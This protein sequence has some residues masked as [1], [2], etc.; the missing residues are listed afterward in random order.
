M[1]SW[2]DD[3]R[4]HAR[5]ILQAALEAVSPQV[6]MRQVARDADALVLPEGTRV[7]LAGRTVRVVALGKAAGMMAAHA[8]PWGPLAEVVVSAPYRVDIPGFEAYV[9]AHPLPDEES[10]RAG[11]RA[12]E[13]ARATGPD[14][15]LILLLSGGASAMAEAPAVPLDD[16]RRANEALLANGA[17]IEELNLVRRHLSRLKG[18]GLARACRGELLALCISDVDDVATLGSG[19]AWPDASRRADALRA[20]ERR[21][22][23][24]V[25]PRSVREHL[26][27]DE[28]PAPRLAPPRHVV[29]ADNETALRAAAARAAALGYEARVRERWLRGEA[30]ER[31]RELGALAREPVARPTAHLAGGETTVRVVG[32][33]RGGRNQ[34]VALAAVDALSARDALLATMGTDGVDGPTDAAGA[35][36]D[37]LTRARADALGLDAHAHLAENDAYAYF[38]ALDDLIRTGPTGTNVRDVALLLV[39]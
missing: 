37:G 15:L 9:G 2:R 16:L 28:P 26:A 36:V 34:E 21:G 14:D 30:R 6:A 25:V 18:G 10:V 24:D 22:L 1:R 11:E 17:P 39:R 3:A 12:L 7:R 31:G 27:R 29:L 13:L 32:G 35:I 19:P 33:G 20:L 8:Q 4:D 38:D 5:Q 23:A